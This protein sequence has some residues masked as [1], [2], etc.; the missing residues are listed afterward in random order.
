MVII[1][2]LMMDP[3]GVRSSCICSNLILGCVKTA[4]FAGQHQANQRWG[5]AV[6]SRDLR[7]GRAPGPVFIY[8]EIQEGGKC[9]V[10]RRRPSSAV[11]PGVSNQA[12]D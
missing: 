8:L 11:S 10:R 4:C 12:I 1:S 9:S 5:T 6:L 3:H 7:I 2:R